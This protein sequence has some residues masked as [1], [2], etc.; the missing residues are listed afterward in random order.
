MWFNFEAIKLHSL[1][2]FPNVAPMCLRPSYCLGTSELRRK[3]MPRLPARCQDTRTPSVKTAEG[4]AVPSCSPLLQI[5]PSSDSSSHARCWN[6][7]GERNI[8]CIARMVQKNLASKLPGCAREW[9]V[10]DGES[11]DSLPFT[12]G[13]IDIMTLRLPE[14]RDTEGKVWM[15]KSEGARE[16]RGEGC[17]MP[18]KTRKCRERKTTMDSA[19]RIGDCHGFYALLYQAKGKEVCNTCRICSG[20]NLDWTWPPSQKILTLAVWLFTKNK[21]GFMSLTVIK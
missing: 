4:L 11:C 15:W 10:T 5:T 1:S 9:G 8:P 7:K 14:K 12:Q 2:F 13:R 20:V 16:V 18:R 19:L 17:V 21:Q 6:I 3:T